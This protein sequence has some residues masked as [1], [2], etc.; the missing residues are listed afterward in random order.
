M[1]TMAAAHSSIPLSFESKLSPLVLDMKLPVLGR[2]F[3]DL[4]IKN[5]KLRNVTQGIGKF[6]S[7]LIGKRGGRDIMSGFRFPT[8]KI[9][10]I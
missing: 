7:Y 5:I 3:L 1:R 4:R 6:I 8:H 2:R 9:Q 10:V